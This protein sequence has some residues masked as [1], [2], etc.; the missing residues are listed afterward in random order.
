MPWTLPE[1]MLTTAVPQPALPPGFAGEPKW[2]GFRPLVSVDANRVVLRSRRGSDLGPAFPEIL[3][4]TGRLPHQTALDGE[5][6][7]W[8]A[9]GRLAFEQLQTARPVR[10]R[11]GERVASAL[12]GVRCHTAVRD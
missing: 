11:G 2:D 3:A 1:L 5:L 9:A 10:R 12:R 6:V 4:G 7:V 8:D